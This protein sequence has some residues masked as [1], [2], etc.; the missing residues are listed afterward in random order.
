MARA[1]R[2]AS[3]PPSEFEAMLYPEGLYYARVAEQLFV[4]DWKVDQE[5]Q[6]A[7]A[8]AQM[9]VTAQAAGARIL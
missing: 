9:K 2:Y 5:A 1:G 8:K 7:R 4:E 6:Q 3:C